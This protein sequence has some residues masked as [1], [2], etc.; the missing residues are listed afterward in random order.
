M[1]LKK[2]TL[3]VPRGA[4]IGSSATPIY[5]YDEIEAYAFNGLCVHKRISTKD[6][7]WPWV[8]SH[9]HSGLRLGIAGGKTKTDA[10]SILIEALAI[11]NWNVS[12]KEL[13]SLM[14]RDQNVMDAN[15]Y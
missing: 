13:L 1:K 9:V 12:E 5:G 10:T 2:I 4:P 8:I 14:R 11:T 15:C 6:S 7:P 3:R